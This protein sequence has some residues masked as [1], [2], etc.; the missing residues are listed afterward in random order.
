M[1]FLTTVIDKSSKQALPT[2]LPVRYGVAQYKVTATDTLDADRTVK[3]QFVKK[4]TTILGMKVSHGAAGTTTSLQVG[5]TDSAS[6]PN[7]DADAFMDITDASSAG[8]TVM[9]TTAAGY[10]FSFAE[11]GWITLWNDNSGDF[12]ADTTITVEYEYVVDDVSA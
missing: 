10:F 1:A 8:S 3:L 5:Y 9:A 12:A 7:S 6:T 4:G 11:D 2:N